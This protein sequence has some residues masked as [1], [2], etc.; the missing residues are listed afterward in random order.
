MTEAEATRW[1]S[2]LIGGADGVCVGS[3][4][5]G[6]ISRQWRKERVEYVRGERNERW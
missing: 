1:K 5:S 6:S 4:R 2:L 3:I